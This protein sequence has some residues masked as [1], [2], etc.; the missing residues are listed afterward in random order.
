M[1]EGG[2]KKKIWKIAKS[3]ISRIKVLKKVKA[4]IQ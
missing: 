4:V 1:M 3:K 2:K